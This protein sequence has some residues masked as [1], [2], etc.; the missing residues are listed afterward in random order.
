MRV[1]L[2][3]T[4]SSTAWVT[5]GLSVKDKKEL[6]GILVKI[7]ADGQYTGISEED[8]FFQCTKKQAS[9]IKYTSAGWDKY[10]ILP[11][12]FEPKYL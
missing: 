11:T 2:D 8:N 1:I 5:E 6:V 12:S 9:K 3:G 4:K 7:S 10:A